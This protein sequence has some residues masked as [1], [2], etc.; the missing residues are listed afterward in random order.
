MFDCLKTSIELKISEAMSILIR[1]FPFQNGDLR[2]LEI[3]EK[4]RF[5]RPHYNS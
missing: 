2:D 4:L 3:F 1:K 5:L